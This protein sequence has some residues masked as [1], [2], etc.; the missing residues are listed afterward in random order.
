MN[1][2]ELAEAVMELVEK[3]RDIFIAKYNI[4]PDAITL[5]YDLVEQ[6]KPLPDVICDGTKGDMVCGMQLTT[7]MVRENYVALGV[8]SEL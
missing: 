8:N 1:K 6:L 5:S 4:E 2:Y 7:D 3:Y